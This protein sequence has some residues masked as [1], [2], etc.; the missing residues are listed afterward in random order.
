MAKSDNVIH[1]PKPPASAFNQHRPVSELI[2][3]QVEHLAAVVKKDIDDER[4]AVRT[5]G[6]ASDFIG[7]MTAILRRLPK[8]QKRR[9]Q[10]TANVEN[11]IRIPKP[12]AN[13]LNKNRPVSELLWGQVEDLAAVVKRQIEDARRAINTEGQASAFIKK[14]T[15][16]LHPQGARKKPMRPSSGATKKPRS[17]KR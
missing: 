5:E 8:A 7:Q 9:I 6:H 14:M 17:S 15:A 13:A 16:I 12:P 1:I 11:I 2:W 4:R 3:S 10:H